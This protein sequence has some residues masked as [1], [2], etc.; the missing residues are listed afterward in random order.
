MGEAI[1]KEETLS[2]I[3]LWVGKSKSLALASGE[4]HLAGS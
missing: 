2:L 3:V 1:Y 4:G